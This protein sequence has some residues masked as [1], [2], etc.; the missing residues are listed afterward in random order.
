[1]KK[2]YIPKGYIGVIV[3]FLVMFVFAS[4]RLG[5]LIGGLSMACLFGSIAS[6]VVYIY[7]ALKKFKS[8]VCLLSFIVM[9]VLFIVTTF[10]TSNYKEAK[11][12]ESQQ[13]TEATTTNGQY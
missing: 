7:Y 12:L 3:I 4:F 13:I 6:L 5:D 2:V 9:L 10:F 1:M 8:S 11:E